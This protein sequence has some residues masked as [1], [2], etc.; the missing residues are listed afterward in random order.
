[1]RGDLWHSTLLLTSCCGQ[2]WGRGRFWR[3]GEMN[4]DAGDGKGEISVVGLGGKKRR[5]KDGFV[6]AR[7]LCLDGFWYRLMYLFQVL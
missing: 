5:R 2:G 3:D 6:V 1:M 7:G 4:I